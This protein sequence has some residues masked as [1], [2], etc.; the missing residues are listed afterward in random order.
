MDG[1][2]TPADL[3]SRVH[4]RFQDSQILIPQAPRCV[5]LA[6]RHHAPPSLPT[7]SSTGTI[8][9][10]NGIQ[11]LR[12]EA[13]LPSGST[14]KAV[15]QPAARAGHGFAAQ[16]AR[17][18]SL[19]TS[20]PGSDSRRTLSRTHCAALCPD[21]LEEPTGL[22]GVGDPAAVHGLSDDSA[23]D[24]APQT[25]PQHEGQGPIPGPAERASDLQ[26]S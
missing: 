14:M 26:W 23:G 7:T 12:R 21:G 4:R 5:P 20:S 13:G 10:S 9:A 6:D 16:D 3:R 24:L 2:H 25:A 22:G 1:C 15:P 11:V 18:L 17:S 8:T 19:P